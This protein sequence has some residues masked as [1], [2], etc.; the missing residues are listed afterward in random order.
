MSEQLPAYAINLRRLFAWHLQSN[1]DVAEILGTTEHTVGH[2]TNGKH[3]P[4]GRFLRRI[5]ETYAIDPVRL[6][7]DP[8]AF[9]EDI[10][11]HLRWREMAENAE[12][13]RGRLR[14]V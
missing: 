8:M 4:S 5:G 6:F 9:G 2:W 7:G 3:E 14:A 13:R 10:A 11:S 1:K 12:L